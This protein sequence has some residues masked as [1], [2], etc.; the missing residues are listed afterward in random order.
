MDSPV[1]FKSKIYELSYMGGLKYVDVPPEIIETLGGSFNIRLWC[2]INEKVKWQCGPVA[3]G[4][5]NAYIS[6]NAQR[7]KQLRV[8]IGDEV[9]V[10][11]I[12]DRSEFGLELPIEL[13]ELLEQDREGNQRFT[14]LVP[15]K[16]RFIIRT[17]TAVKSSQLRIERS[18]SLIENL[19][20]LAVGK[21][22][23]KDILGNR[24]EYR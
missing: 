15:G 20:K 21:E 19:K 16:Q 2:T 6:V 7:I 12:P 22:S 24:P 3:A 11:L 23:F 4:N 10:N 13:Q 8:N 14:Q 1:I 17:V 9:I 18:V 5:G